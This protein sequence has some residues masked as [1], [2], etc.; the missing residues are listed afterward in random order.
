MRLWQGTYARALVLV[1]AVLAALPGAA[2]AADPVFEKYKVPT[3]GG[4]EINVEVMRPADNPDAPVILTYSPYNTLSE[5]TTPNLANDDIG[6]RYVPKGYARA[7]ADVLGTRNS[8]GCWDYGGAD[9]Q[10]SGVDLVNFL[11]AQP[12]TNGKVAMIGGSYDGTTATM[13]ATRG[14]DA[15]GLAAIVPIAGISRWYGYAY[16]DGVRYFLNSERP[17]DEGIDTPLAF[18]FGLAR[19]PPT[20]PTDPLFAE[21]L[22][23]RA[24][25]CESAEHTV[26]GYDRTPDY[27]AFWLERD[28]RKDAA[29]IRAA[30]LVAH[31]WQ[32]YNVKQEEGVDLYRAL[33][34]TPFKRLYMWQAG[35]STPGA[36][37]WQP[38]LDR[39]FDHTLLGVANGV[40]TEPPVITEGRSATRK[41]TGFRTE[42][43][44]PPPRTRLSRL[45]LTADGAL[46]R[47]AANGSESFT[48]LGTSTEEQSTRM[49]A[50]ESNWLFF[51]GA[52]LT[53]DTRM[54][55]AASLGLSLEVNRDHAHLTPLL[56][57]VA[58]D[59]TT[60]TVSRGFLN[61]QYRDGLARAQPIP[62]NEPIR[63][64]VTFKPQDQTFEAGH[65]I[66]L[67]VQASNTVW[68]LPDDPGARFTV[69][70]GRSSA[71][72]L[73]LAP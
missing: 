60:K 27:D 16:G 58:P 52:P 3:V 4:A 21:K 28:Y 66:G 64:T 14:G 7:V 54:T 48:D 70:Y 20:D 61:L 42:A 46:A 73:P 26:K 10:Q 19:T 5:Y 32:D 69:A 39:F 22:A 25:P 65:R 71:L 6:Q 30:A 51:Q 50:A 34:N 36:D 37:N 29:N 24:N 15:P 43:A 33:T 2:L 68:A 56:V 38:L 59:G 12:W 44:W 49:P 57:D 23:S 9:E 1:L 35:H 8:S 11:A 41:S 47:R 55:G 31:G 67:I 13:V 72:A 63:A 53:A 40:D 17:T 45:Y 62:P 18:D